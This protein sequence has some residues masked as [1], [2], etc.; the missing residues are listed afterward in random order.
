MTALTAHA[1]SNFQE[2]REFHRRK[3]AEC[4]AFGDSKEAN[5]HRDAIIK[6][7]DVLNRMKERGNNPNK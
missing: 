5:R 4:R 1:I 2:V 3:E 6:L 7:S